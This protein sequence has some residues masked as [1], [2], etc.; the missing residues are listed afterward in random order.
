MV[1]LSAVE[2]YANAVWPGH[3]HAVIGVPDARKGEQLVLVTDKPDTDRDDLLNYAKDQGIAEL[4]VPK[5]I[6]I[7]DQIPVLGT[8]KVDYVGV[9]ALVEGIAD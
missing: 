3:M 5:T 8:G 6:H 1:S 9:K 4:M 7:V 2:G